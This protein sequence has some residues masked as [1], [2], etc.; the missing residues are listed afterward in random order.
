MRLCTLLPSATEVA[1]ALGLGDAVVA[2]SHEC[3]FPPEDRE[4]TLREWEPLK[5]LAAWQ[6]IPAVA[7][8]RVFAVDG[9][10]YF[11]RPGPRLVDGLEILAGF[12]QGTAA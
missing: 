12:I 7:G 3:D 1:F 6:E 8:G 9:A 2:V 11:N 10:K 4:R 5:D